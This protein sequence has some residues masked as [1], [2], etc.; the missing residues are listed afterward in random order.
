MTLTPIEIAELTWPQLE[1][2]VSR[3]KAKITGDTATCHDVRL[4][5]KLAALSAEWNSLK[6]A[7]NPK[8]GPK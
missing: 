5:L 3:L 8:P 6:L 1:A 7:L 4:Y 2:H